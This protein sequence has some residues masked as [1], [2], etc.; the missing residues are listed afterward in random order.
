MYVD[1]FC[2]P[3]I[4]YRYLEKEKNV[5]K[6]IHFKTKG[7][8]YFPAVALASVIARYSFLLK[9]EAL[10]KQIG[11]KIP[12]GASA[13][14]DAFCKKLLREISIETFDNIVKKNFKNYQ[15]VN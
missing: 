7:E 9:M 3:D 5:V 2:E 11:Q 1:Q 8:S 13:T 4:Y 14:V 6:D 12:F 10:G 15:R